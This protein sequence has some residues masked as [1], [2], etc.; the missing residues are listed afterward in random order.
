MNHKMLSM[1]LIK[2]RDTQASGWIAKCHSVVHRLSQ[3]ARLEKSPHRTSAT[4]VILKEKEVKK[5]RNSAYSLLI[6]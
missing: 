2:S 4:L 6:P 3:A 5:E 1:K